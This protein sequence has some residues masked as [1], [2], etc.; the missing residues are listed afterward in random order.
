[1]NCEKIQTQL[2]EYASGNLPD[3]LQGI[4]EEHLLDCQH[5]Q[6]EFEAELEMHFNLGSLPLVQCPQQVTNNILDEIEEEERRHRNSGRFWLMGAT[7]LVAAGLALILLMP[8][9]NPVCPGPSYSQT[10]IRTATQEAQWALAKV[11]TVINHHESTAFEQVFGQDIPG[12]VGGSLR[13][14]TKNLQGE[15]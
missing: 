13:K 2:A 5:C 8:T 15:V 7:T 10:E 14:I 6:L 11:A 3:T 9:S 1:M 12:A 4:I